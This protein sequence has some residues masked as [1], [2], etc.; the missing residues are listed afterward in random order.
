MDANEREFKKKINSRF[1][2]FSLKSKIPI[3]S[4]TKAARGTGDHKDGSVIG[5]YS[6]SRA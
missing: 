4:G 5:L 1:E 6:L 2:K 3:Y